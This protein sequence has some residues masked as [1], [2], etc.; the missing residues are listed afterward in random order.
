MSLRTRPLVSIGFAVLLASVTAVF[1]RSLKP[2]DSPSGS[3]AFLSAAKTLPIVHRQGK[4]TDLSREKGRL[5]V[6]HFWATWC[7]PCVEEIP[8]LSRFWERYKN[9]P[10]IALYSVSVDKDWKVVEEFN[11]KNPNGLPLYRDPDVGDGPAIRYEPVPRDL[12]HQQGRPGALPGPGSGRL[13]RRR[14]P[15][16]DRPAVERGEVVGGFA[17]LSSQCSVL[18]DPGSPAIGGGFFARC[19][20]RSPVPGAGL[21]LRPAPG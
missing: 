17:V 6:I 13:E 5:L 7:P 3:L 20:V 8:A 19:R 18:S 16:A 9:R 11:R 2:P 14:D 15:E 4:V 10:D 12:H 21:R 1:I